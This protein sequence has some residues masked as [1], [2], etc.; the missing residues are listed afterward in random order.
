MSVKVFCSFGSSKNEPKS[1]PVISTR[2]TSEKSL[3]PGIMPRSWQAL[4]QYLF[5]NGN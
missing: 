2:C 3:V 1:S 4:G 5:L